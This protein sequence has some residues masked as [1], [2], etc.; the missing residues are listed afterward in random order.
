MR[1]A[2]TLWSDDLSVVVWLMRVYLMAIVLTAGCGKQP[3]PP[4]TAAATLCRDALNAPI[5]PLSHVSTRSVGADGL[6]TVPAVSFSAP[7]R[8]VAG[9]LDEGKITAADTLLKTYLGQYPDDGGLHAQHARFLLAT[10]E[11]T[12]LLTILG[13]TFNRSGIADA[14]RN[15]VEFDASMKPYVA[16]ILLRQAV[17]DIRSDQRNGWPVVLADAER[18]SPGARGTFVVGGWDD[19]AELAAT[20]DATT[21]RQ[22]APAFAGLREPFVKSG[23]YASALYMQ[24]FA[25]FLEHGDTAN[26][27][28]LRACAKLMRSVLADV[29]A[30]PD[31]G[32]R[33]AFAFEAFLLHLDGRLSLAQHLIARHDVEYTADIDE[34]TRMDDKLY[35]KPMH[36]I[37]QE[38]NKKKASN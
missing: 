33:A 17:Q 10:T 21:S 9:L 2:K 31:R 24:C 38:L 1:L 5:A 22:W 34:L 36:D 26:E 16:D 25:C 23:Y 19:C 4:T 7:A 3:M 11:L 20:I 32:Q 37:L 15:A 6:P 27:Q 13:D 14:C 12:S 35:G 8:R 29:K 28:K 30:N 18:F